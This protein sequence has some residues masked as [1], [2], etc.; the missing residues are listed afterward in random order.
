MVKREITPSLEECIHTREGSYRACEVR[1]Y[2]CEN[3]GG[4]SSRPHEPS[5]QERRSEDLQKFFT[6][7][8]GDIFYCHDLIPS[9]VSPILLLIGHQ[10]SGKS[11]FINS[12][13]RILNNEQECLIRRAESGPPCDGQ[14]T[15]MGKAFPV[16]MQN[17]RAGE[18]M[19][20]SGTRDLCILVDIP[21]FAS[22]DDCDAK[23]L[24]CLVDEGIRVGDDSSSF[25]VL[26]PQC[27]FILASAEEVECEK[28][29]VLNGL[30]KMKDIL[31]RKGQF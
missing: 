10:H 17:I 12:I 24:S 22:M 20:G 23:R 26:V 21:A 13:F 7:C 28:D 25:N 19:M 4:G 30:S 27:V 3:M 9:R 18:P 14:T 16:V 11:S 15:V 5:P 31:R 29:S 6:F 1:N 8:T 2:C